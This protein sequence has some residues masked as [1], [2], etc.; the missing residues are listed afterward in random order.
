MSDDSQQSAAMRN[1]SLRVLVLTLLG[2]FQTLER[3][4][5]YQLQGGS[6]LVVVKGPSSY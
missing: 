6:D 4:F 5:G 3:W 2:M 1:S